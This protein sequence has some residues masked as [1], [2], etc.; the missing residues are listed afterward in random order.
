MKNFSRRDIFRQLAGSGLMMALPASALARVIG[1]V[2]LPLASRL[3]QFFHNEE[4]ARVIGRRYL[5]LSPSEARP[6]RLMAL[7][8]RC[9][10]NHTRLARADAGQLRTLLQDQQRADF[11]HG[12]TTTVDG[13]ILSETEVRLCALAAIL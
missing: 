2:S 9:E 5:E 6:E 10:E 7:I 11:T 4:S 1:D 8:C 3:A 13:W 12:R